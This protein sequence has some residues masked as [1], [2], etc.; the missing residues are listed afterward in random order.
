MRYDLA[1][2]SNKPLSIQ[3]QTIL[4]CSMSNKSIGTKIF[5]FDSRFL[6]FFFD[7]IT[8]VTLAKSDKL[9]S[10]VNSFGLKFHKSIFCHN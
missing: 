1:Y 3:T 6:F 10:K 9:F 4:F 2:F 8:W 7:R 5:F